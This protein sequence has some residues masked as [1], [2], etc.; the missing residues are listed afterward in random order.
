MYYFKTYFLFSKKSEYILHPLIQIVW[1]S[2]YF[3]IYQGQDATRSEMCE[4]QNSLFFI[5][6][7]GQFQSEQGGV[8]T[9]P[10]MLVS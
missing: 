6:L 7:Q 3:V 4:L 2:F 5:Q 8:G 10:E 9:W 1:L